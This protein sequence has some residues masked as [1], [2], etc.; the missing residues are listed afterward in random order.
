M[1]KDRIK[2]LAKN[3]NFISGIYNYCDRWCERCPY[4]QKCLNF[5]IGEE[6]YSDPES[7][8][9]DNEK[10]WE[11]ISEMFRITLQ[12]IR[13]S[14]EERGINL[15]EIDHCEYE[16]REK[17]VDSEI[18]KNVNCISS[19]N[20]IKMVDEWFESSHEIFEYKENEI[21][22]KVELG[23]PEEVT[24]NEIL[25]LKDAIEVI[26][27]YQFQIHVKIRRAVD[28]KLMDKLE[29]FDS[30]DEYPKDH[31][32]SAK[33]AL[34]GID[35]SVI[36]WSKFL[37]YFPEKEDT[38][39]DILVHLERLR[40]NVEREFPNARSFQRPGFDYIPNE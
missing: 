22:T 30:M 6:H 27:W 7:R 13:E 19:K 2:E 20:Y 29:G 9:I 14:A 39:M 17:Q 5:A 31:D 38:V 34:I 25:N 10:F 15:D 23:L 21:Y 24:E 33:V 40:R 37:E 18:E 26:R 8:D 3:P 28:G 32:G 11:S 16:E 36:M 35:R 12:M 1:N 4:T